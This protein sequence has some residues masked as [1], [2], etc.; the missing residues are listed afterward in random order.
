MFNFLNVLPFWPKKYKRK[1]FTIDKIVK[2]TC[3]PRNC[4]MLVYDSDG[5]RKYLAV[6][7][8]KRFIAV[9]DRKSDQLKYTSIDDAKAVY[10]SFASFPPDPVH[11]TI[12][13]EGS[14]WPLLLFDRALIN[15]KTEEDCARKVRGFLVMKINQDAVKK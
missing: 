14:N 13:F 9:D 2:N 3:Y 1:F 15:C 7:M 10:C 11:G 4:F 12:I 5:D 8:G 6:H